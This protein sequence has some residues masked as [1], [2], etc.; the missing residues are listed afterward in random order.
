LLQES[1][2]AGILIFNLLFPVALIGVLVFTA[3]SLFYYFKNQGKELYGQL[4]GE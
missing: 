4:F 2:G 1:I 3:L